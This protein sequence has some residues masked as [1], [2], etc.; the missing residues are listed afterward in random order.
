MSSENDLFP[1]NLIPNGIEIFDIQST[2]LNS[3]VAY[4]IENLKSL[5]I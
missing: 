2:W 4:P 3:K 1:V 5:I